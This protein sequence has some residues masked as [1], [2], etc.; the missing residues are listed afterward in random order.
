MLDYQDSSKDALLII[1]KEINM[2]LFEIQRDGTSVLNPPAETVVDSNLVELL[3]QAEQFNLC[4]IPHTALIATAD[5]VHYIVLKNDCKFMKR[6]IEEFK[7][8][9]CCSY[10]NFRVQSKCK[11]P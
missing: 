7:Y 9:M 5:Q 2:K 3:E 6:A 10:F 8:A 4:M 1:N 11:T